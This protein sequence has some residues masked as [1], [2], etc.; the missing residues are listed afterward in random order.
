MFSHEKLSV[1]QK[2][3]I[4][5]SSLNGLSCTWDKRHALVDHLI[6]ASES[7]LMNLVEGTRLRGTPNRQHFTEYAM[8][9]ALECAACLDIAVLKELLVAAVAIGQKQ[10]DEGIELLGRIAHMLHVMTDG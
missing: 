2:A 1:Y 9:S 7:I 3:L 5:V 4:C 6:R 8:G 10:R